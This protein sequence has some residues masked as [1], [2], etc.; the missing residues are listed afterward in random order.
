VG[1]VVLGHQQKAGG[2]LVQTVDQAGP[3][4]AAHAREIAQVVQQGI[5]QRA[6]L[7]SSRG[8]HHQTG[9]LVNHGQV[10][11][12]IGDHERQRLGFQGGGLHGQGLEGDRV[13]RA[14]LQPGFQRRPARHGNG[15]G[16]QGAQ[17]GGAAHA[18][19]FPRQKH[20]QALPLFF[21]RDDPAL[22]GHAS[23]S[24]PGK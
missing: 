7:V 16:F 24:A 17:D 14:E 13:P 3:P 22:Y 8:V 23:T 18:F 19:H 11:V 5:D 2:F 10:L 9:R 6:L 1:L 21:G 15:A 4:H 20:V 12:L